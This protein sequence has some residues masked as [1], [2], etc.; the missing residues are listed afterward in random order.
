MSAI[1]I[2]SGTSN[3]STKTV[4]LRLSRMEYSTKSF[5]SLSKRRSCIGTYDS[6][7]NAGCNLDR[8]ECCAC[9][10]QESLVRFN[11]HAANGM[12]VEPELGHRIRI[13]QVSSIKEDWRGH[14]FL[15]QGK[16][17][18]GEFA[19]FGRD[20]QGFGTVY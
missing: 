12:I 9:A 8:S 15:N 13:K 6:I 17:D 18:I 1:V 16:I 7:D 2:S 11:A 19:P 20:N 14:F 3:A 5:A 4:S 10:G